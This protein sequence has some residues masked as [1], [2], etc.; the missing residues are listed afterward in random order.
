MPDHSEKFPEFSVNQQLHRHYGNP[1]QSDMSG[2]QHICP[3]SLFIEIWTDVKLLC[4]IGK[5][6]INQSGQ[7]AS[8]IRLSGTVSM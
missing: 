1:V 8:H 3:E 4:F 6:K 7:F 5:K 2:H